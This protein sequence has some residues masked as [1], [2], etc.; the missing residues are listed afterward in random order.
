[1]SEGYCEHTQNDSDDDVES[2]D[3]MPAEKDTLKFVW[4]G[5][6]E[7]WGDMRILM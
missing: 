6:L 1:M 4:E 3:E 5:V 2:P 7:E